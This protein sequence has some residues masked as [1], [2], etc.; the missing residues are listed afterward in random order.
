MHQY[1]GAHKK[2]QTLAAVP[3]FGHKKILHILVAGPN[4]VDRKGKIPEEAGVEF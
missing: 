4:L 2:S 1:R 3:L